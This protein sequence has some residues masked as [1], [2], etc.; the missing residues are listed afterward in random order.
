MYVLMHE[1]R[2]ED[3]ESLRPVARCRSLWGCR[4]EAARLLYGRAL[5]Y[6]ERAAGPPEFVKA[7]GVGAHADA[8]PGD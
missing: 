5:V 6:R 7:I 1:E 4:S 2:H 8:D 3:P